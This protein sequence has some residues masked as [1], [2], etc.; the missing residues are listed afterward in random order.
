M[1]LIPNRF[2]KDTTEK[3]ENDPIAISF[4]S[5]IDI[6][7]RDSSFMYFQLIK[8]ILLNDHSSESYEETK[9]QMIAF[10]RQI[11]VD[12]LNAIVILDEFE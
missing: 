5:S 8:E 11:Y 4:L 3:E 6:N 9:N 7:R 12:D 2:I 10:C 1:T